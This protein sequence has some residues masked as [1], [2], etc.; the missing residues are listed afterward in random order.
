MDEVAS[1]Y[2]LVSGA[3]GKAVVA[4]AFPRVSNRL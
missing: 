2:E 4:V 1:R 3:R